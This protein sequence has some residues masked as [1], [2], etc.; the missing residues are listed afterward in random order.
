MIVC[1]DNGDECKVGR[2]EEGNE[3]KEK[4]QAI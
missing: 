2:Y 1:E 3:D 4:A